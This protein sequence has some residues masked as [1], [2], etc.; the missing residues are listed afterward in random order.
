M[1]ETNALPARF[2]QWWYSVIDFLIVTASISKPLHSWLF[3][4]LS[5]HHYTA[6]TSKFNNFFN[7]S[8]T[9]LNNVFKA[10][11]SSSWRFK[12]KMFSFSNQT[13]HYYSDVSHYIIY[14]HDFF[15]RYNKL[16]ETLD[17]LQRNMEW[18]PLPFKLDYYGCAIMLVRCEQ[19]RS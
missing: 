14:Q 6:L 5:E 10:P 11:E 18:V 12:K 2:I 1:L 19:W 13:L 9:M 7:R 8:S 15:T 4:D 3:I 16:L 17:V